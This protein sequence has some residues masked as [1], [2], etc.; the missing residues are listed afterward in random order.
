MPNDG[1]SANES[2]PMID[3]T[4]ENDA[5]GNEI[6]DS[7]RES[8]T[9]TTTANRAGSR[10]TRLGSKSTSGYAQ[11]EDPVSSLGKR[12]KSGAREDSVEKRSR[13]SGSPDSPERNAASSTPRSVI[14]TGGDSAGPRAEADAK[15]EAEAKELAKKDACRSCVSTE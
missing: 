11:S 7:E 2:V 5:L 6:R 10:L 1:R 14:N 4:H 8:P 12:N 13:G 9:E 15:A 3:L